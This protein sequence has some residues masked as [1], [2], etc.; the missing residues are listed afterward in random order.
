MRYGLVG[1][2]IAAVALV[3][4]AACGW[5]GDSDRPTGP[6]ATPAPTGTSEGAPAA[7]RDALRAVEK[8]TGEAGSAR[9]TSTTTMGRMLSME[10][11]GMLSWAD[12]PVGRLTLTYTG[13]EVADTMRELGS[14]SM[15]ARLL[16]DAYYAEFGDAFAT[17]LHGRHWIRYD[18][19][20]LE[21]L[22]GGSGAQLKEELERT[23]PVQPIELLLACGSARKVG[24][25][26]VDGHPATRYSGTLEVAELAD[27]PLKRRLTDAGVLTQSVDLWVDE[28]N[29][30]VKKV[31]KGELVETGELRQTAFYDDY[32]LKV[33][34]ERPPGDDTVNFTELL[35]G[36]GQGS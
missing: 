18:H 22:P 23:A 17:R 33:T 29:L 10:T 3:T 24:P 26:P 20:S 2:G 35:D 13:G 36:H 27:S 5:P 21:E 25:D 12:R 19:D 7:V 16:P 14:V 30:L 11:T 31:E 8:A 15:R 32:G 6:T 1:R 28:R 4:V 9:V 34:V